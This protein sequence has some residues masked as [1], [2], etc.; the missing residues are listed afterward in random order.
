[1]SRFYT[2]T[3]QKK[4]PKWNLLL[5]ENSLSRFSIYIE[6]TKLEL[7]TTL[8]SS[9]SALLHTSDNGRVSQI[10]INHLLTGALP[11]I[12]MSHFRGGI[13]HTS[14]WLSKGMGKKGHSH[15]DSCL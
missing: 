6:Q 12:R 13:S 9:N 3:E 14:R 8:P 1:M 10:R 2:Y 5:S 7:L 15:H 11:E 4:L